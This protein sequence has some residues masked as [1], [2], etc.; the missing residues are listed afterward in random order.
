MMTLPFP[1]T[2]PTLPNRGDRLRHLAVPAL[3]LIVTLIAIAAISRATGDPDAIDLAAR[4]APPIGFGGT[5]THPLGTDQ[6]GR[7]ILA[8]IL[9]AAS[10]SLLIAIAA[11]TIA[12]T[13]GISLGLIGGYRGGRLDRALLWLGDVQ[14][15]LPFIV[16]AIGVSAVLDPSLAGVI[17]ILA[18]TGWT[19]YAR[20]ARL[21]VM[22]LR[23][24]AFIDAARVNGATE[25]RIIGRHLLPVALT[26]LVAI[27]CQQA[28]AMILYASALSY[29]GLAV[30][31]DTITWGSMIAD[32]RDLS[33]TAW[34]ATLFPG[35]AIVLTVIG[36]TVLG[37]WFNRRIVGQRRFSS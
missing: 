4:L 9:A 11:T 34:W 10:A 17:L 13:I 25:A 20:I 21:T 14:L 37:F 6:L 28:G 3:L 8:R 5:W 31:S 16:V 29:L 1:T 36:F 26:P 32:A 33:T 22:P 7:D 2:A 15:A 19:T 24:A 35:F 12:A 27:A 18:L 23:H 30:P